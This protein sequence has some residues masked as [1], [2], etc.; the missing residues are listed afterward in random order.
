MS[1]TVNDI[2]GKQFLISSISAGFTLLAVIVALFKEWFWEKIKSPKLDVKFEMHSPYC[3]KT[4]TVN[5]TTPQSF[6]SY[7]FRMKIVNEGQRTANRVQIYL[8]KVSKKH[9]D[10]LYYEEEQFQPMNLKWS[11]PQKPTDPEL[12]AFQI[13]PGM[14]KYCD[15]G[16]I[17]DPNFRQFYLNSPGICIPGDPDTFLFELELEVQP[18]T[19]S[20]LMKIGEYILELIIAAENSK[21]LTKRVTLNFFGPWT[22]AENIM[23]NNGIGIRIQ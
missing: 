20:H 3:T 9:S 15:L 18:F 8:N 19:G 14:S 10:G 7:Y 17:F 21:P 23:F 11:N 12:Y 2:Q 22:L 13:L 5:Q 1:D 16:H 6:Y 4:L